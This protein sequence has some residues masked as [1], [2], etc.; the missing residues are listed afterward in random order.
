MLCSNFPQSSQH[1][2]ASL[3]Q[4]EVSNLGGVLWK[5]MRGSCA[6]DWMSYFPKNALNCMLQ[7]L[8]ACFSPYRLLSN[9]HTFPSSSWLKNPFGY[10]IY[11]SS[12]TSPC[13]KAVLMSNC[14]ISRS[15]AADSPYA[16]KLC[17]RGVCFNIINSRPVNSP[18]LPIKPCI[19]PYCYLLWV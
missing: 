11:V 15:L 14:M 12:F 17:N 4:V 1:P 3:T 18:L 9:L 10:S 16:I 13:K 5:K 7:G 6:L 2:R 19:S 8:E